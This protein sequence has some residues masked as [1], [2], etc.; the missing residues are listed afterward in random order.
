ML[1]RLLVPILV[2]TAAF[3]GCTQSPQAPAAVATNAAKVNL[4]RPELKAPTFLAPVDLGVVTLGS[5]PSV[6]VAP[7][8]TVYVATPGGSTWRSDDAGKTFKALGK[9]TCIAP[10]P[11]CP[12]SENDG[13]GIDDG[14]DA[15]LAVAPNGTVWSAGLGGSAG[16][17][18]VQSS[19]DK[20]ASWSK[21]YDVALKN[22]SDREWVVANKT[23]S[24]F[25]SWRDFGASAS[26]NDPTGAS[27]PAAPSGLLM[28][29]LDPG[30]PWS[31]PVKVSADGHEGPIAVDNASDWIYLPHVDT[32]K[33]VMVARSMDGGRT[34]QDVA[35]APLHADTYDFPIATVD[36]AGN[37]YVV[38]NTD[39]SEPDDM[40]GGVAANNVIVPQVYYALSK[41]HGATWSKPAALSPA[42]VPALFPWAVAGSEGRLA[43]AWYEGTAPTPSDRV[44]NVWHVAVDMSVTADAEKAAFKEAFVSSSPNHV[45]PICT[46]GLLCSLTG[47]DRSLLDFFEIRLLPDGSP[48]LAFVGD[49]DVR[50]ATVHVYA[51]RMTEGTSMLG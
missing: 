10:L 39:P 20:G 7:D 6:A 26:C 22:G 48:V 12:T 1:W 21:S 9:P 13:N 15:S 40:Q 37:V 25:V 14:G 38:W 34:W 8:S 17:V 29:R 3:V 16:A 18:P 51:S 24:V 4:T 19:L 35:A 31:K 46:E 43:V 5:E 47:A 49:A 36:A 33:S 44:P 27:C 32:Q 2:V 30:Q 23:G 11:A 28:A 50:M 41:D 45:G 42:G